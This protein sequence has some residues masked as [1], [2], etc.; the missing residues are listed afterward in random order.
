[1]ARTILFFHTTQPRALRGKR[2][3]SLPWLLL[4]SSVRKGEF[5]KT[6]M[7]TE[8]ARALVACGPIPSNWRTD[9]V[10]ICAALQGTDLT[11]DEIEK[12]LIQLDATSARGSW[13]ASHPPS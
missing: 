11:G 8:T 6:D 10:S 3:V 2:T 13:V 9:K 12:G 5:P 1:V 7:R 4:Q